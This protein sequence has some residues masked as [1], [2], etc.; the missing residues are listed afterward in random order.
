MIWGF[1]S[2]FTGPVDRCTDLSSVKQ[3]PVPWLYLIDAIALILF[4]SDT[5][6]SVIQALDLKHILRLD[7]V[8]VDPIRALKKAEKI[9]KRIREPIPVA[10]VLVKRDS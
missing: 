5:V 7:K 1:F 10:I 8:L 6:L 3:I 2:Y 9:L 4:I